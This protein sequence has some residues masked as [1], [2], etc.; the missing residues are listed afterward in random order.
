MGRKIDYVTVPFEGRDHG[1]TY[2]IQEMSAYD[3]EWWAAR[4]VVAL[5]GTSAQIP[6]NMAPLGMIA[7]AIRGMNSFLAAD[8]DMDKVKP[9]FDEMMT[10]ITIVPDMRAMSPVDGK[11]LGRAMFSDNDIEEVAT[12]I[13]LRSEVLRVHTNFSVVDAVLSW[14]AQTKALTDSWTT[15]MSPPLSALPS[16]APAMASS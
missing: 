6:E 7:V 8:V 12:R 11:P 14:V 4:A 9:L 3:A 16:P 5:K 10:C 13:W 1:K 15:Q 2:R